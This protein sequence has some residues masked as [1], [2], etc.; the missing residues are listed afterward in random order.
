MT[1]DLLEWAPWS[2]DVE[3]TARAL[4][5]EHGRSPEWGL[6]LVVALLGGES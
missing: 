3:S 1:A 5:A 6:R 2:T 4:A